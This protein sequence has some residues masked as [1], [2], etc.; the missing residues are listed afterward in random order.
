MVTALV[1]LETLEAPIFRKAVQQHR[2]SRFVQHLWSRHVHSS[3]YGKRVKRQEIQ[4]AVAAQREPV[5]LGVAVNQL[6]MARLE[7]LPGRRGQTDSANV[8]I[9]QPGPVA[10]KNLVNPRQS[11]S[12]GSGIQLGGQALH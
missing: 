6:M 8:K 2:N 3:G 1:Q 11:A 10:D 7:F 12:T 5:I 4:V 9:G